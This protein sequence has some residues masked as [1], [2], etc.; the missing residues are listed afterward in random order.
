M[1]NVRDMYQC[2]GHVP[3][4]FL[5]PVV[6]MSETIHDSGDVGVPQSVTDPGFSIRRGTDP[7]GIYTT[8]YLFISSFKAIRYKMFE[9]RRVL[10]LA[11]NAPAL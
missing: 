7:L 2:Q 4:F 5:N 9:V 11:A 3:M 1:T 10:L 8:L 6:F